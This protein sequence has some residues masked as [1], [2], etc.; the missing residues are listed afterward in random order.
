MEDEGRAGHSY[1]NW[2]A[3]ME[4]LAARLAQTQPLNFWF[5]DQIASLGSP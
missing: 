3:V 1:Q 2:L 5:L 4:D